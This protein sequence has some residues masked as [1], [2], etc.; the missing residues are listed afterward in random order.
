MKLSWHVGGRQWVLVD[1]SLKQWVEVGTSCPPAVAWRR[2]AACR[3]GAE[4]EVAVG[5]VC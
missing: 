4:M 3:I 5:V 2:G 1:R